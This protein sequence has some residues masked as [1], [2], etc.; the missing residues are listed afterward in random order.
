MLTGDLVT[1]DP[2]N[3]VASV[4]DLLV[5]NGT[6][7]PDRIVAIDPIGGGT[8][9]EFDLGIDINPVGGVYHVNSASF[10]LLDADNDQIA[11]FD[12][13]TLNEIARFDAPAG[14]LNGGLAVDPSNGHLWLTSSLS[15]SLWELDT[16]GTVIRE[17]PVVLGLEGTGIAFTG[18]D[19]VIVSSLFGVVKQF[20]VA[21]SGAPA[22]ASPGAPAST[23]PA[24]PL[25]N[26]GFG[27][28]DPD[29]DAFAWNVRGS[30]AVEAGA[31]V[32]REDPA[33]NTGLSQTFVVPDD[34]RALR[35]T[36]VSQTLGATADSPVDAFEVA[37]LDA[38]T[39]QPLA[40][41]VTG[42]SGTDAL[43][44]LQAGGE[45]FVADSLDINQ[46]E[47]LTLPRT[48]EVDLT[49]VP[50]GTNATIHFDLLGFGNLEAQVVIDD[51][52][53]IADTQTP[54]QA[55]DDDRVTDED[56]AIDIDV[57][58]NDDGFGGGL[59]AATVTAGDPSNGSVQV[60][61]RRPH[62][63]HAGAGISRH[64]PVHLYSAQRH[65]RAVKYSAGQS[66]RRACRRST[67]D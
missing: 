20:N 50:A 15:T 10:F 32:L 22:L 43:F 56:V 33:V 24:G 19:T 12:P 17:A 45:F 3:P 62:P 9:H 47:A 48:I 54:P 5:F 41:A 4:G 27:I 16:D 13:V 63:L 7:S 58:A 35:F 65:G 66:H 57:L 21:G 49:G 55:R 31:A 39:G 26:G 8:L 11:N 1:S 25:T 36:I 61:G 53:V 42:L 44:N 37:L 67:V 6:A 14:V 30:A 23:P 38:A 52:F 59:D 60:L 51:V 18:S 28:L 34:A 2:D 46:G 40:G 64:G 29:N